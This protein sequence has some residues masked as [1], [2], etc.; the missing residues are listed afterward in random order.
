VVDKIINE[1]P[2]SLSLDVLL[3]QALKILAGSVQEI[4]LVGEVYILKNRIS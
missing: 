3:K 4:Y 1:S 2:Q